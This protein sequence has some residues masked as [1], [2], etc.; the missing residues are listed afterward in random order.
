MDFKIFLLLLNNVIKKNSLLINLVVVISTYVIPLLVFRSYNNFA[1]EDLIQRIVFS[2]ILLGGI[3]LIIL[4]QKYFK[5]VV[6]VKASI[7][8]F[9]ILGTIGVLYSLVVLC[10]IFAF[11]NVS[12]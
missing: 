1:Y 8:F 4:N 2:V 9:K 6:E 12:F 10:L 3:S 11:Q 5:D 7:F